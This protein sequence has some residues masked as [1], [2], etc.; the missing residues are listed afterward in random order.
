MTAELAPLYLFQMRGAFITFILK[1]RLPSESA[2]WYYKQKSI[3][4]VQSTCG[5]YLL[6]RD[7]M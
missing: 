7:A 2:K 4:Q 5:F 3:K 1:A 6:S